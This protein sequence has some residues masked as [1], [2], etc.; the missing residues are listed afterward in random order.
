MHVHVSDPQHLRCTVG[1]LEAKRAPRWLLEL[2]NK[3]QKKDQ[4]I[5]SRYEHPR[6]LMETP[7]FLRVE[8]RAQAGILVGQQGLTPHDL[9]RIG[10]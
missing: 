5:A 6:A 10:G 8:V 9:E 4:T 2:Q 1:S 3:I 7:L